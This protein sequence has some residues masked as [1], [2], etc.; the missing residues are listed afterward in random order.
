MML[1]RRCVM[2][3]RSEYVVEIQERRITTVHGRYHV[4]HPDEGLIATEAR[5]ADALSRLE[6]WCDG[7]TGYTDEREAT[8]YDSMARHGAAQLWGYWGERVIALAYRL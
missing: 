2:A 8:V 5:R 7:T 3:K 1:L 6:S 4:A